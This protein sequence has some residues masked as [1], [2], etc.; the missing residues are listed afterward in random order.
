[1]R[2]VR[3]EWSDIPLRFRKHEKLECNEKMKLGCPSL[4][5]GHPGTMDRLQ[6]LQGF[7]VEFDDDF[8]VASEKKVVF[9]SAWYSSLDG[10]SMQLSF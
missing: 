4:F 9:Y 7:A 3:G 2:V 6:N 5:K 1:M 10:H 8:G